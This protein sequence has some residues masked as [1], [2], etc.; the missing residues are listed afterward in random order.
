MTDTASD[1]LLGRFD[2]AADLLEA[3]RAAREAGFTELDAYAPFPV[4]GLDEALGFRSRRIPVIALVAGL[5]AAA[6]AFALQW[7][8]AVLDYPFVVGGKPLNSWPA[9]LLVTFEAGVLMAVLAALVAML[10]GNRLPR[11][12]H[13]L[14]DL[15]EFDRASDDG[16]FLMV[17]EADP[18][19]ARAWLEKLGARGIEEVAS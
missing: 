7:W 9:F 11:P 17:R 19:E 5:V 15:R 16:F 3:V 13:P 1:G 4:P 6:C 2:S 12:H 14:F 18:D 8:S 10:V